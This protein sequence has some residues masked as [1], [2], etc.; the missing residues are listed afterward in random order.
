M[1]IPD[2]FAHHDAA[3]HIAFMQRFNFATLV[4]W[5]GDEPFAS[6]LPLVVEQKSD[7]L[8]SI[9]GH[10]ARK[11]P[12]WEN[13]EAQT[14]LVIFSEPHAYVSPSL[15]EKKLNVPTWNYVAVHAYGAARLIH[16]DDEAFQILE[17]QMQTYENQYLAQWEMLPQDYKNGMIK[18]IVAFEISVTKLEAKYKLSQN[19]SERDRQSVK[20]H[21][22]QSEDTSA[23]VIG[24][25]MKL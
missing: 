10:F 19:K 9:Y 2:H 17:K 21:L 6:H 1:Y 25:M 24:E 16:Q 18:G 20:E 5:V 4:T 22:L 3:D 12:Q 7:Q 13:L 15:Y 14:A 23:K 8:L 11:N